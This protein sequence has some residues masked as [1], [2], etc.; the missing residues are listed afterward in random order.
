MKGFIFGILLLA[1]TVAFAQEEPERTPEGYRIIRIQTE[2][3]KPYKDSVAKAEELKKEPVSFRLSFGVLASI[4]Y[5]SVIGDCDVHYYHQDSS[6]SIFKGAPVQVGLSVLIPLMKNNIAIRTGL[7]FETTNLFYQ[8]KE[9]EGN[10]W[11]SIDDADDL[12]KMK[13]NPGNV[14]QGRLS[15]PI[16]IAAKPRT[17]PAMFEGGVQVS[18]PIF[19]KHKK[20]DLIDRELRSSVDVSL[21]FGGSV[22]LSRY[23]TLELLWDLQ[24]NRAYSDDLIV[25]LYRPWPAAIKFGVIFTPF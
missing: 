5:K 1:M 18:L 6:A 7:L 3:T 20:E 15:L 4:G 8:K 16:M 11:K 2:N 22:I 23:F 13:W 10:R 9:V 25:G 14:S 21:I 24:V 19:E 12:K 17:S